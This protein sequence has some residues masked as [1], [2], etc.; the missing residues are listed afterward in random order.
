M[1]SE[2]TPI[3]QP[4]NVLVVSTVDH[5]EEELRA[6]LHT[7][8]RLKVVV[9]VVSQGVLDWLAN[10]ESAFSQAQH[11]AER[12]AAELPGDEVE[13]LAGE[14]DVDLAIRDALATFA[15]DEIVL[16]VRPPEQRGTV[17]SGAT[18]HMPAG[19]FDGIP[20]RRVVILD[21]GSPGAPSTP[22]G[23]DRPGL[24]TASS[25]DASLGSERRSGGDPPPTTRA[26]RTPVV[27]LGATVIV[28][29][30]VFIFALSL[31]ALAYIF[32]G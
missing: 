31:A 2:R 24:S 10:D 28:I 23:D 13:A 4:R 6:Y 20:V 15:A 7:A 29:A 12:T 26:A 19:V 32:S 14:A 1:M 22:A 8:D 18:E 5:P 25:R 3:D 27:A 21:A 16:A 30:V 9:P 17:E 11:V